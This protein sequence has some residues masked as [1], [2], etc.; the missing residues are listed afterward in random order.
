MVLA[1]ARER[2]RRGTDLDPAKR[3]RRDWEDADIDRSGD[4][5]RLA[6]E[7]ARLGLEIG[8]VFGEGRDPD[9][10]PAPE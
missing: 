10:L 7:L 3:E 2:L 4:A 6:C 8:V 9:A 1:C 5:D